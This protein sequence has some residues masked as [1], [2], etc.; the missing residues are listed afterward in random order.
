MRERISLFRQ[1]YPLMKIT[2]Y[3]LRRLYAKH[4]IRKKVIRIGKAPK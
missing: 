1:R 2:V 3:K 4:K